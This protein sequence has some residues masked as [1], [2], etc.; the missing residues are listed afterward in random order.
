MA[1]NTTPVAVG[2]KTEASWGNNVYGDLLALGITR[3]QT[4]LVA[5]T[6]SSG[7]SFGTATV[8]FPTPFASLPT[9]VTA[10]VS[11]AIGT[12]FLVGTLVTLLSATQ[13]TVRLW[14]SAGVASTITPA[15]HW[16]ALD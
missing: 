11:S 13:F 7:T 1:I 6:V 15:V 16:I 14:L 10:P 12:G 3:A 5:V 8:T 9:I 2:Q 4:G